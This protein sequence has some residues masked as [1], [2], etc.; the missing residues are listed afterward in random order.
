MKSHSATGFRVFRHVAFRYYFA[1]R[2]LSTF[3]IQVISVAV[4][5]QVY[6]VTRD[7]FSLG[8]IGLVQFMP[9]LLL[10]PVTGSVADRYSRRMI[11]GICCLVGLAAS[12]GLA[13]LA[14]P[15]CFSLPLIY[16][17]LLVLGIMRAFLNPAMQSLAPSLVPAQNLASAVAWMSSSAKTAQIV[18]P[19]AGG[20]IYLLGAVAPY[21]A[22]TVL[23]ALASLTVFA[24]TETVERTTAK[25]AANW[26]TLTAGLR[27]IMTEK[28]VLGAVSLDM[29]A[30]LLGGAVALM[31]VFASDV[32]QLGPSTLGL[33]RGAPAI[34]GVGM[35]FVLAL[36]PVRKNAGRLMLASVGV[37]GL[38]TVVFGI[39]RSSWLSIAALVVLGAADMFSVYVRSSLIA[40][41]TPDPL[42]GR[43]NA[44]NQVFISASNEIG[45]FRA[46]MMAGAIGAV[47][48]V[49][50]GGAGTLAVAGLWFRLFPALASVRSLAAP[51][52]S[53][54]S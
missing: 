7:A 10:F 25:A 24:I 45:A 36:R 37:F 5:W 2:F 34:G 14:M 33:L 38:A 39:S 9:A 15:G 30:I 50:F 8:L 17:L 41:W 23:F 42:R 53:A 31:P 12:A 6:D 19:V 51:H 22:S 13:I 26:E 48:T 1:S 16:A 46:G 27:Y 29:F 52:N 35:A 3:A 32:L 43:V 11:F 47:P 49:L 21:L 40:L 54:N 18:G 28:V 4:G 20:F 44:V